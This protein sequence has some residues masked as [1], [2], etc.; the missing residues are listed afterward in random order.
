[1]A[2]M[3]A[4]QTRP[5]PSALSESMLRIEACLCKDTLQVARQLVVAGCFVPRSKFEDGPDK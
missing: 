4:H 1:M 2:V 5:S 3:H